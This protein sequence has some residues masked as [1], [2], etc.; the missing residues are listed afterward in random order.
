MEP[1]EDELPVSEVGEW[2][3]E[4]HKR[5][6]RYVSITRSVRKKWLA[7]MRPGLA[8]R[9][10]TY[11]DLFCGPGRSLIRDTTRVIDGSPL[12]ATS[13]AA[14]GNAPFSKVL[15]A[16]I[17]QSYVDASRVRLA[18]RGTA[19]DCFVG[20]ASETAK[21]IMKVLDPYALHFAFLDPFNLGDLAFD[22]IRS[23]AQLN[24]MDMLIHVSAQDLQRNLRRNIELEGSA[25][26][27]FAP[28]WREHVD[29][30]AR[31]EVIRAGILGHWLGLIRGLDMQPSKG[32]ELVSGERNQRLYWLVL[33][34]RHARA[35]EFWDKVRNISNQPL[36]L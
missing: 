18:S 9:G 29:I 12:V 13:A 30:G 1:I 16:D 26:D 19:T 8:P 4:K 32:I 2:T 6:R 23:L 31:D 28:G 10:A 34:S 33:V 5:L 27:R 21:Q 24:R 14:E 20:S 35:S 7:P 11:I 15:L 25:L 22:A 17:N 3:I 36:L